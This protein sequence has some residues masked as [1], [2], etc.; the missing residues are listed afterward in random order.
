MELAC[1]LRPDVPLNVVGDASRLR[2]IV[3]NLVGNAIKFTER[4]EI[5]LRVEVDSQSGDALCL[6]FAVSDTG[7]GI[8]VAKQGLIFNVFEQ[9]DQSTTR[10]YGGSGLGLAI[11]SKIVKL[12]HGNVWVESEVGQGSTF[13]F[14]AQFC[15]QNGQPSSVESLPAHCHHLRVLVVDDNATNRQ[16]LM[17]ILRCWQFEPTSV[18]SGAIALK[19]LKEA[20]EQGVP[21]G[22]VL[23]DAQMP[24][25]DGFA[26]A[27]EIRANPRIAVGPLVMLSSSSRLDDD[28]CSDLRIASVLSKPIRQVDLFN[29]LIKMLGDSPQHADYDPAEKLAEQTAP[30]LPHPTAANLLFILLAEDNLVNQRVARGILEKRGHTVAIA[31]NGREALQ[32]VSSQ[33]FD[34]VLMDVQMPE[35]DGIEATQAIRR[36]EASRGSH[37]PIVAMTAHALTGDRERC[38]AAGMDDYLTKPIQVNELLIAIKR[39]TSTETIDVEQ[40]N[41]TPTHSTVALP[42]D[43][44]VNIQPARAAEFMMDSLDLPSLLARVEQDFDLLHEMFA[45]FLECSPPLM[46]EIELSVAR[47]EYSTLERAAHALKGAL[48]SISAIPAAKAAAELESIARNGTCD[49]AERVLT[50]LQLEFQRLVLALQESK[51]GVQA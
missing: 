25:L 17:E 40:S 51:Q 30:P 27:E 6:H 50:V 49:E 16:I 46:A 4:G 19:V 39:L 43:A 26:V 32:A 10:V 21:F 45:L 28:R 37:T 29:C 15:V 9:A 11:V 44:T 5:V 3:I 41:A 22:L 31:N 47:H 13:H 8:P 33:R 42:A 7:I 12:M 23:L 34:L 18:A 48:Q 24:L 2:Q 14:T 38:L 20:S 36:F 1:H 35:M